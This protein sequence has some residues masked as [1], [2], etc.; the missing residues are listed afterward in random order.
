M[1]SSAAGL[2]G[3]IDAETLR[4][5][6]TLVG[7]QRGAPKRPETLVVRQLY[8]QYPLLYVQGSDLVYVREGD[9]YR[10][11]HPDTLMVWVR[12]LWESTYGDNW[13]SSEIERAVDK[14]KKGIKNRIRAMEKR[15]VKIG[16]GIFWDLEESK[17]VSTLA[18]EQNCFARLFDSDEEDNNTVVVPMLSV[19]QS[20][21]IREQHKRTL[22]A[23]LTNRD[24]EEEYEF[25][26]T[27]A[28]GD[29]DV[30][31]D[32]LRCHALSFMPPNKVGSP[33]LIGQAG[34]GKSTY[35]DLLHS[36]W[37]RNN[38]TQ[39]TMKQMADKHHQLNLA[40]SF[41]NAP[42]EEQEYS[43]KE[44]D[45]VQRVFK[46]LSARSS[47]R[48]EKMFSQED[49][50]LKGDFVSYFPM[51]HKPAWRGTSAKALVR[52]SLIVPFYADLSHQAYSG[53][54]FFHETFTPDMLCHYLGTLLGIAS[55][56]KDH[57]MAPSPA[58]YTQ[59]ES[60]LA[61]TDSTVLYKKEFE[62][63]FDGFQTFNT[64]YTDY[65]NWCLVR[66]FKPQAKEALKWTFGPYLERH[67][68][69][70]RKEFSCYEGR[71]LVRPLIYRAQVLQN[72]KP[73][74]DHFNYQGIG[75]IEGLHDRNTNLSLVERMSE[76]SREVY[77][78]NYREIL[79]RNCKPVKVSNDMEQSKLGE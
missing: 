41:M 26:R 53:K 38:T 37:G 17:F 54:D 60:L 61:E 30:Y 69:R 12:D 64:L 19:Q 75:K 67:R 29:H 68:S 8:Q 79:F 9:I 62:L 33:I 15:L 51:N 48:A 36:I 45:E 21:L 47:L 27:W 65:V 40:Y 28:C 13:S 31:M 3:S 50:K 55:Y 76:Q 78:E 34:N 59:Q 56:Y 63:F 57:E 10:R 35:L 11:V 24:L 2:T 52:R 4:Q 44:R 72:H 43:D 14:T 46:V 39:L 58:M 77:G 66:D 16:E 23:L 18:P 25:V 6:L 42:D 22:E 70:C 20:A 71:K 7:K 73:F 1:P 49:V 74:L 5:L 32:M